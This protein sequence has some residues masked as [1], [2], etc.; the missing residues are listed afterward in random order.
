MLVIYL[1]L[2]TYKSTLACYYV[3][4]NSCPKKVVSNDTKDCLGEM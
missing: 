3:T 2:A 1:L 4:D